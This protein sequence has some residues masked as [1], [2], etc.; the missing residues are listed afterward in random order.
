MRDCCNNGGLGSW[1]DDIG[2]LIQT[3]GQVYQDIQRPQ[4]QLPSWGS[5][6]P[7]WGETYPTGQYSGAYAP[8][9]SSVLPLVALGAL[10]FLL[11]RR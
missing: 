4:I 2:G 6:E 3:A 5:G 10:A 11:F 8:Q 9:Q 1:V 7:V